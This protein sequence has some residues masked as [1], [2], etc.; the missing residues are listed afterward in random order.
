MEA[1]RDSEVLPEGGR[2]TILPNKASEKEAY[3]KKRPMYAD[4]KTLYGFKQPDAEYLIYSRSVV[5]TFYNRDSVS[6]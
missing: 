2:K 6:E 4:I 1:L 5:K 3:T